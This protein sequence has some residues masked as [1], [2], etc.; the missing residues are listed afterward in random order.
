MRLCSRVCCL[1]VTFYA[2]GNE[3]FLLFQLKRREK[4][5]SPPNA[6][7]LTKNF[8]I[9]ALMCYNVL[10]VLKLWN[11]NQFVVFERLTSNKSIKSTKKLQKVQ[12]CKTGWTKTAN[13]DH[14][15][16]F[17]RMWLMTIILWNLETFPKK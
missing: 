2:T 11:W 9:N 12:N 8:V 16:T 7:K 14:K 10:N 3:I 15:N 5:P 4:I 1:F 17:L 6:H 13:T